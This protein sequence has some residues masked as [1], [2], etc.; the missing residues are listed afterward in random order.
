MNTLIAIK[1]I[2]IFKGLFEGKEI[3]SFFIQGG[4]TF[5][6]KIIGLAFSYVVMLLI[7]HH[8]GSEV[9]GRYSIV[10][11]I[12]SL[13]TIVFT[14]GFPSAL[15]RLIAD[16]SHFV[17]KPKTDFI[18]S[19]LKIVF[20]SGVLL[21]LGLYF[22]APAL[23]SSFFKDSEL[24]LYLQIASCFVIPM[25]F[26]E[27][28][29]GYFRGR[30]FFNQYNLFLFLLPP[31][32]FI[33]IYFGIAN[34]I[35]GQERTIYAFGFA[36]SII[37]LI[38]LVRIKPFSKV[39]KNKFSIK[40]LLKL[41]LPMMMSN[42]VLF[43]LNWTDVFMLGYFRPMQEVGVYNVAFKIAS[44]G[45]LI[46]IV[47]NV[48]IAP[49]IALYYQQNQK[50]KLKKY[51]QGATRL[52]SLC[53]IPIILGIMLFNDTLLGLFGEDFTEGRTA[54]IILSLGVLIN[55]ISGNVDQILNMTNQQV[56]MRNLSLLCILLNVILNFILIPKYGING[57]AMASLMTTV[58]LNLSSIYII[59]KKLGF[60]TFG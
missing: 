37:F 58:I 21:S 60:Y 20:L 15:V 29:L 50:E 2:E 54:L 23:A 5:F 12:L 28:F 42:A 30:S 47:F 56:T 22:L 34:F 14:F 38:E 40:K 36:I 33:L 44:L 18:E 39:V 59:K 51:I 10:I 3:R 52:I 41:S 26:H 6:F 43:L 46:L 27:I 57:A 49:Q 9:F 53:T 32:F 13:I 25:M 31:I 19:I 55:A 35:P 17:V 7:T 1:P 45:L 11:T 48:I 8:F 16:R 4:K 24:E